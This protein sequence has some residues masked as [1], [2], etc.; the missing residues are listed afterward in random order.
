LPNASHV[1]WVSRAA[2]NN[3]TR[4]GIPRGVV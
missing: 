2:S 1:A 3:P 4:H